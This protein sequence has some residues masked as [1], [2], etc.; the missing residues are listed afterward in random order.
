MYDF[1][2]FCNE[3]KKKLKK[4]IDNKSFN[5]ENSTLI[6]GKIINKSIEKPVY[7]T[8]LDNPTPTRD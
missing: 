6:N 1:K 4:K 2:H 8:D 5:D 7:K 3:K